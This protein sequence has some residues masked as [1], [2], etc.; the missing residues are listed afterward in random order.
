[1]LQVVGSMTTKPTGTAFQERVDP[2]RRV[3]KELF[4]HGE[5]HSTLSAAHNSS[6]DRLVAG[7]HVDNALELFLKSYA[8]KC[9]V[10]KYKQKLVPEL[11]NDLKTQVQELSQY[12]GDLQIFHD[13][14]DLAYHLGL[15]LDEIDLGWGIEK[16]KTFFNEVEKRERQPTATMP[17]GGSGSSK[18][19]Q[20]ERELQR[21]IEL[22]RELPSDAGKE[23]IGSVLTHMFRGVEYWLDQKLAK[24]VEKK[25]ISHMTL[26]KKIE[27]LRKEIADPVLLNE[28]RAINSLR[29]VA[30]HSRETEIELSQVYKYLQMAL[31]FIK[32][33]SP[34][35]YER[36]SEGQ[37]I[38]EKIKSILEGKG[39]R[40]KKHA[41]LDSYSYK[42]MWDFVLDDQSLVIEMR[43][44]HTQNNKLET[45]VFE[46]LAFRIVDLK[47][48][49]SKWR[50]MIVLS[51]P[52]SRRF[53]DRMKRYSDFVVR[54]DDFEPALR[55]LPG[56]RY[57]LL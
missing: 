44:I 18:K 55:S 48:M 33:E 12:G 15:A 20:A 53:E 50:S 51:G 38:E 37:R 56:P 4:K 8:A 9:G 27:T 41:T 32:I 17:D 1:M 46:S 43:H 10:P 25:Q 2:L 52:W 23:K 3:S 57:S 45:T 7:V 30:I 34:S 28:L 24:T 47:K 26:S 5:E 35:R 39:I 49:N 29:N 14:R 6:F 22:F 54:I 19:G 42:S 11:L 16:I 13:M 31:H 21:A 36:S 40:Y